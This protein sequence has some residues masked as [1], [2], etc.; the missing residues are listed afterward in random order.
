MASRRDNA[1]DL[2]RF[3]DRGVRVKL[4]G[5]REGRR[6]EGGGRRR[7]RGRARASAD[8]SSLLP[9]STVEGVLKGYDQLLNLV[10]DEAL[11]F[12]RGEWKRGGQGDRRGEPSA[13]SPT[14]THPTP[15]PTPKTRT[16]R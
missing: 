15:T 13:P 5:G 1:L 16:T 7:K 3:V 9:S 10:L 11:E 4:S 14:P 8:P 6:E 2:A 12:L